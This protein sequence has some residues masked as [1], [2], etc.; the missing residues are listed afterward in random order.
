MSA[1]SMEERV[2]ALEKKVADLLARIERPHKPDWISQVVGSFANCPE[3]DEVI[4]LGREFRK[5][6][7]AIEDVSDE[8]YGDSE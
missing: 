2:S 5:E 8:E 3:F 6:Q 7:N 4:R 1:P